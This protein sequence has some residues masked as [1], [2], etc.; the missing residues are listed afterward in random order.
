MNFPTTLGALKKTGYTLRSIKDEMRENLIRALKDNKDLF[1]GIRGYENS[2]IPQLQT[3]ILS[4]HKKGVQRP[5]SN[6]NRP[7]PVHSDN[8]VSCTN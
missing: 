1:E 3:A 2:V 8:V 6:K 5:L 4:K 7:D